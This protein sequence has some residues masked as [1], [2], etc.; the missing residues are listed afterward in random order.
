MGSGHSGPAAGPGQVHG[1]QGMVRAMHGLAATLGASAPAAAAVHR[2]RYTP[3][4]TESLLQTRGSNAAR[5]KSGGM[6][7]G[8]GGAVREEDGGVGRFRLHHRQQEEDQQDEQ[9]EGGDLDEYCRLAAECVRHVLATVRQLAEV[10]QEH[11][12]PPRNTLPYTL[13]Y[14]AIGALAAGYARTQT[15]AERVDVY[16][17]KYIQISSMLAAWFFMFQTNKWP[18]CAARSASNVHTRTASSAAKQIRLPQSGHA[19]PPVQSSRQLAERSL[20]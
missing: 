14:T 17:P 20:E 11:S 13:A 9:E 2:H 10:A 16:P 18:C 4:N 6:G 1:V 19:N 15:A 7:M 8:M 5:A 12:M 3:A